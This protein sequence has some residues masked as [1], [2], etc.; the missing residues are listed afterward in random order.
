M[1]F[2]FTNTLQREDLYRYCRRLSNNELE[3]DFIKDNVPPFIRKKFR[4][5]IIRFWKKQ[6]YKC[7]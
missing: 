7:N 5:D 4:K 6:G 2:D 1:N 3:I